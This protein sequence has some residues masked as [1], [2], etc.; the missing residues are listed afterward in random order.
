MSGNMHNDF[1]VAIVGAGIGGLALAMA[2]HKK[3]VPFTLY[4]DA[5]EFSAVGAGIGFAPNG[6][7][8][9]DLIEP[10]FRPLQRPSMAHR[11][12]LLDIMTSFIP[13]QNVKFNKR[14]VN[15]EQLPSKIVLTF[16]DGEVAEASILAGADGIKSTVREHVLKP[17]FP[18]QVAPVYADAYCYRAVIPMADAEA[19]LGDLTD[20]AK[21]YFGHKRCAVTYRISEGKEFNYLLCVTDEQ[22]WQP[23][24]AVTQKV[25]HEAMMADF[26][27]PGVDDRFRQLLA[28]ANPIRWGFFHH[29]RTS[30]YYRGR[31]ALLGDSAHAS[32]PFQAAG[33]AQGVEDAL[34]LSNVLSELVKSSR[35]EA[36]SDASI[37]AGLSAYGSVRRPRAQKQ[38]EQAAEVA[39]ML[40]FQHEEAGDDMG[41]I[42]PRLQQGR[43]DWLW[44]HNV[45]GDVDEALSRMRK[46]NLSC[47]QVDR[48]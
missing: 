42:L 28:K 8:A 25:S 37:V 16:A 23:D 15:I 21:F 2:L 7:R 22:G 27:G 48:A 38:L 11:K 19:I 31:V 43:F 46:P 20:V 47:E 36:S 30:T 45:Q 12:T 33:A 40:F 26:E 29:L 13:R 6:M 41:K 32:L 44:F 14:L 34:V 3:S 1:H 10:G 39:R 4:E 17:E 9:M 24:K 35:K 18:D 5:K